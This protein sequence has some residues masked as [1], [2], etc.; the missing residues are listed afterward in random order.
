[1]TRESLI[2]ENLALKRLVLEVSQR[3]YL[4]ADVL[5]ILAEKR[6]R[7]SG[8]ASRADLGALCRE[9]PESIASLY[10]GTIIGQNRDAAS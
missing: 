10:P 7:A 4:A 1:M 3:L 9:E 2:L 8:C 6:T 5:S